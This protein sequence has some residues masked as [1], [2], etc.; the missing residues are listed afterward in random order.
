MGH[1][2]VS[3]EIFFLHKLR[4]P[5]PSNHQ[6]VKAPGK[7]VKDGLEPTEVAGAETCRRGDGGEYLLVT[8]F[9]KS[10]AEYI[11]SRP[12]VL[13]AGGWPLERQGSCLYMKG[14]RGAGG[15]GSF[16]SC[17]LCKE[18]THR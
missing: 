17:I 1:A 16:Y 5:F 2:N 15:W 18:A 3:A 9:S 13:A 7:T 12:P 11:M 8:S 14:G 10:A 6:P 4:R